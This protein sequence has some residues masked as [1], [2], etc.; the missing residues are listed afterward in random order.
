[1]LKI[2]KYKNITKWAYIKSYLSDSF[3]DLN[4]ASAL[5]KQLNS[6]KKGVTAKTCA[7]I[8]IE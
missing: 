5:Q 1:M 2:I 4:T 8:V 3:D 7:N 6:L